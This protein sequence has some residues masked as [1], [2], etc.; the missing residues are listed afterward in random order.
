MEEKKES[1][2]VRDAR[3]AA[4]RMARNGGGSY[5]KCLDVVAQ[6]A[7]HRHWK[8]FMAAHPSEVVSDDPSPDAGPTR[9]A[10][11]P[12][13]PLPY[14]QWRGRLEVLTRNEFDEARVARVAR[15]AERLAERTGVPLWV[16]G[17]APMMTLGLVVTGTIAGGSPDLDDVVTGMMGMLSTMMICFI[18]FIYGDSRTL[19]GLRSSTS[20]FLGFIQI[21]IGL[22]LLV[23]VVTGMG[24][25]PK[26]IRA[27][28]PYFGT[29]VRTVVG[30][31]AASALLQ[32]VA[33]SFRW[34]MVTASRYPS[35]SPR[36][37]HLAT[38]QG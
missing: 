13:K 16:V 9:R 8:A 15:R 19:S 30:V 28:S 18:C 11:P 21:L 23:Y 37:R 20:D 6:D 27:I 32:F 31:V 10:P 25:N 29:P 12:F 26:I 3:G 36:D 7:G 1:K 17:C 22:Y 33:M 14:A 35:R 2:R 34:M 38:T 24:A 4:R 5:Q